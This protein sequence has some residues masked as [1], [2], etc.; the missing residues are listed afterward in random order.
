[1]TLQEIDPNVAEVL[2]L[3]AD[4]GVLVGAVQDNSPADKAGIEGGE[5]EV[6]VAGQTYQIG[7]DMIVAMDGKDVGTVDDLREAIASHKPGETVRVTVVHADGDRET[8]SV[9][10]ARVPDSPR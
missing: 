8:L 6:V 1:M 9:K 3:P 7:G 2:K 5:T 10:L 4:K